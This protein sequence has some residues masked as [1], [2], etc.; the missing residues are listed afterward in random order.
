MITVRPRPVYQK[1]PYT[2][3]ILPCGIAADSHTTLSWIKVQT[4]CLLLSLTSTTVAGVKRLSVSQRN[5]KTNDPKVFKLG[6]G[7]TF[8]YPRSFVVFMSK[9]QRSRSQNHTVQKHIEGDRVAGVSL[10]SIECQ[11]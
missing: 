11:L 10:Y 5:S 8:G 1:P 6:M 7:M 3:V 2:S 9:G 4:L